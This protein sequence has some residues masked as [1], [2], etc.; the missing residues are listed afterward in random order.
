[1]KISTDGG[2]SFTLLQTL[3]RYDQAYTTPTWVPYQIDLANY[4]QGTCIIITFTGYSY[5]GGDQAID[6]IRIVAAQDM[7][8]TMLPPDFSSF[9]ACDLD[10]KTISVVMENMTNQPI[11]YHDGDSIT[12]AIS[13]ANPRTIQFP[14][15][16][17]L[18]GKLEGFA[19]DT[20][21]VATDVDFSISGTY[22]IV[23][24]VNAIDSIQS[25]DTD[26][27][28]F[29][30]LSDVALNEILSIDGKEVGDTVYP[31]VKIVN[32][33]TLAVNTPFDV[34]FYVN[35][36]DTV[37]ETISDIMEVGDTIE[38][39]FTN[40]FIVPPATSV[41]P[42]YILT[43][44]TTLDCDGQTSNNK[45]QYLGY[46]DFVDISINSINYPTSSSYIEKGEE[47]F[48][49]VD[50]YNRGSFASAGVKLFVEVESEGSVIAS[51]SETTAAISS[52]AIVT[53]TFTTPYQVPS[54]ASDSLP[55]YVK[56]FIEATDE[57]I[58]LNNDT[59][60]VETYA[61]NDVGIAN[62]SA[63]SWTLGQNIP[64]P[65]QTLTEIP[66]AIPVDGT[67]NVK[68]VSISGQVLYQKEM[69]AT[70]GNH[71]L[72]LDIDFLSNGIY[73]Y[74]MEYAGRTIVKKM[75]VNK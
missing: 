18:T 70:A 72:V 40:Y 49:E 24:Y 63:G 27:V 75:T 67:V 44:E 53:H 61:L 12:I 52:E 5:G 23:A 22:D 69:Q 37:T 31:I 19:I 30:F 50:I 29:T 20:I 41:Q 56:V 59:M 57:D 43:V 68:I 21:E 51:F 60:R 54:L 3:F 48:V 66:Y 6:R 46:V 45:K 1:V 2:A 33:G 7:Q 11:P 62:T 36:K 71:S 47:V 35:G 58:D 55:Y 8:L 26:R 73:Y 9:T 13:G 15:K 28:S 42:Y 16:G 64:N 38:Y 14:L 4:T 65:A 25:N 39:T 17:Y 32:T 74:S 34:I 10:N